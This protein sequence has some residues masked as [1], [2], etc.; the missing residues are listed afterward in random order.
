MKKNKSTQE[1]KNHLQSFAAKSK[2]KKIV[3]GNKAVIYNRCSTEKQDSLAWQEKVC[4]NFCNQNGWTVERCFGEK[5]S[6]TTDNR[7]QFQEMLKFCKTERINHIVIFSYDRFSR[8]G[9]LSVLKDLRNRGIKVH[10]ATQSVDDQTPS[11]RFSQS[12]YLMFAEME[13]EQRREK[14]LE[15]MKEKLQKG[16][17][18]ATPTVGYDKRYTTGKKQHE[19]DK[20]QCFI[21]EE[22]LLLR[23]AFH[24]KDKEKITNLEI[25]DRL[26][27]M[28]LVLTP[29]RLTRIFRNP[30][31]CGYITHSLL[32]EGEMIL[33]KHEPLVSKEVFLRVNGIVEANPHGWNMIRENEDMPLKASVRCCKCDRPLT[34][35]Y[36]KEKYI[37]YKCPN[38]S[39]RVHIQN[40]KLHKVFEA[41]LAKFTFNPALAPVLKAQLESTYW[42][43]HNHDTTRSKPMREELTRLRNELEAME[44]NLAVGKLSAELFEKHSSNHQRKIKQIEQE[45]QKL[46]DDSSNLS[47]YLQTALQNAN[48]LLKMWHLLDYKGKVRLQ[49]L[50]YPEG[51]VFDPENR[52]VRTKVVNPIFAVINSISTNIGEVNDNS[53][54]SESE[55]LHQVNLTFASSNFFWE[56]LEKT[57]LTLSDLAEFHLYK[58][59]YFPEESVSVSG[60]TF[61]YPYV[62][63]DT[64]IKQEG[65]ENPGLILKPKKYCSGSTVQAIVSPLNN[66]TGLDWQNP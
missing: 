27:K 63:S 62:S 29:S 37:Y 53:T 14:I 6:A 48:N 49:N 25:I 66:R 56:N 31:Y 59:P 26:K 13:N 65:L 5:E 18:I 41:E 33:G 4:H 22:G 58:A 21:N 11:G 12:L 10:A 44:L 64:G 34:A 2:K 38:I 30:F 54:A 42:M 36:K 19:H 57:A 47:N 32:E 1:P 7:E 50:I 60:S 9:D 8:S 28:G 52:T 39:C 43:L 46:V 17:W 23:Q 55:N 35:Y 45:L 61:A 15:G 51:L 16:E 20:K 24:W 40:H 3:I